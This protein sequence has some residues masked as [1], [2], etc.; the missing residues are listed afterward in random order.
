[1]QLRVGIDIGG[2]STKAGQLHADGT[3]HPAE[4]IPTNLADGPGAYL[5]RLAQWA[6]ELGAQDYLGVG[7]PGLFKPETRVLCENP[8]LYQLVGLDLTV[9]LSR[10]L[11]WDPAQV[12]IENDANVAALAES[13]LGAGREL[14]DLCM[15]TLGT[16]VGGGLILNGELFRGS[17]GQGA[18]LG[19]IS[20]HD[21]EYCS[22]PCGCGTWGCLE[23]FASATA[24]IRRAQERKLPTDLAELSARASAQEGPERT[25][26][27]EVGVDLGLGLAQVLVL[28]DVP[29]IV[30]GGGLGLA[31]S[32]L[33]PGI[34]EGI[35]ERDFANRQPLIVPAYLGANAGWIGAALLCPE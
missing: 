34:R 30:I 35:A 20:I 3:W 19:H 8:N 27:Y 23:S 1:M 15:V 6:Q 28:L 32:S 4:P 24:T 13:R 26:L 22:V 31:F 33:E 25:L 12:C 9:E 17:R 10:R 16:G 2:T 11:G 29:T 18:E 5:D 21:R 7:L 14:G